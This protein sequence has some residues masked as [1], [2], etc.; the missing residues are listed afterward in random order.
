MAELRKKYRCIVK[1]RMQACDAAR[2]AAFPEGVPQ[3]L[4]SL[5]FHDER[6]SHMRWENGDLIMSFGGRRGCTFKQAEILLQD[7]PMEGLAWLYVEYYPRENGY[8]IHVLLAD[9]NETADF[10]VRCRG[11]EVMD[12]FYTKI[13]RDNDD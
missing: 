7:K 5:R 2:E 10:I 3:E 9:G 8:E 13:W 6:I 11:I 12:G 1:E 4:K